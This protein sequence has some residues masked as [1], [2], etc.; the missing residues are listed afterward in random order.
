M[1]IA[2]AWVENW[3]SVQVELP[4]QAAFELKYRLRCAGRSDS[5]LSW[6]DVQVRHSSTIE[7]LEIIFSVRDSDAQVLAMGRV[8]GSMRGVSGPASLLMPANCSMNPLI[9]DL[10]VQSVEPSPH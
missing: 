6:W 7:S 2:R 3:R 10:S 4:G 1:P 9:F 5:D 8:S